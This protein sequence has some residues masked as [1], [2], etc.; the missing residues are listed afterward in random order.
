M[1]WRQSWPNDFSLK[2][3]Y[4]LLQR[5]CVLS[6]GKITIG[7]TKKRQSRPND[8]SLKATLGFLCLSIMSWRQSWPNDFSK[9]NLVPFTTFSCPKWRQNYR[10]NHK[11]TVIWRQNSTLLPLPGNAQLVLNIYVAVLDHGTIY[12]TNQYFFNFSFWPLNLFFSLFCTIT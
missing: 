10:R 11:K 7:I 5:F 6:D 2:A 9:G 3:T 8:F 1:S 4:Y 12:W